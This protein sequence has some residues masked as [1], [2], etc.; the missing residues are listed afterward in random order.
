[1]EL[2]SISNIR[3]I[4]LDNPEKCYCLT[5][6]SHEI[7]A[8]NKKAKLATSQGQCNFGFLFGMAAIT[9]AANTLETTWTQQQADDFIEEFDLYDKKFELAKKFPNSE[10]TFWSYL[11]VA[12]YIRNAF[13]KS[14]PGLM[15]RIERNK[16]IGEREGYVRSIH[17]GIR[18]VPVLL[19]KGRDD[20]RREIAGLYNICA[21][22]TIQNDEACKI[23][24]CMVEFQT[25]CD[26]NNIKSY[27]YGMVH[28][29]VDLVIY[30]DELKLVID[31]V[32]EI[33]EKQESWQK[34]IPLAI[35]IIIGDLASGD[36][37]KGGL[38]WKQYF[39]K[40]NL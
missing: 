1:M 18:R 39:K 19:M 40:N 33:F 36:H 34:G 17:G 37:Y 38:E 2:I 4:K 22:T 5:V 26:E 30:K 24:G 28:D 10:P 13:F 31:K 25:W 6:P 23:M 20:D 21:N 14:Y 3:R 8:S 15:E 9:F 32:R 29:S 11:A 16:E 27:M 12:D 35:D 7:C